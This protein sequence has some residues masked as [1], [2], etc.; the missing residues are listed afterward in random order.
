[1]TLTHKACLAGIAALATLA[2]GQALAQSA[3]T[4]PSQATPPEQVAPGGTTSGVIHP[5][6]GVDPGIRVPAPDPQAGTMPVIPPPGTPG[7]NQAV[8]PK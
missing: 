2:A 5:P 7:G 1:M 4:P 6:T 8:Q 3:T